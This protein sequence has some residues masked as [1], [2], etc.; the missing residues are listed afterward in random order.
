M[1]KLN[2]LFV[3]V[4]SCSFGI[5]LSACSSPDILTEEERR[6][7]DIAAEAVSTLLFENDLSTLASYNVRKDGLV[8]IKFHKSITEE[9]YTDIVRQL[10][11]TAGIKR[12]YAE[13]GGK[14]VCHASTM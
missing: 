2:K 3:I 14:E 12:V 9:I 4:I 11:K 10:R 7:Q 6:T 1:N 13:Q 8:V 5:F